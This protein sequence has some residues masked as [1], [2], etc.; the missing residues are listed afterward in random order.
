MKNP[1]AVVLANVDFA[2]RTIDPV[3]SEDVAQGLGD[4]R[5]GCLRLL[6]L[7]STLLDVERAEEG[8]FDAHRKLVDARPL[9]EPLLRFRRATAKLRK[10]SLDFDVDEGAAFVDGD[11][12]ARV[13]ENLVDNA[14]QHTLRAGRIHVRVQVVDRGLTLRVA[15]TAAPISPDEAPLLFEK[16]GR[17]SGGSRDRSGAGFGLYFCRLVAEAHGGDIRVGSEGEFGVVFTVTIPSPP[18]AGS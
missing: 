3:A 9:I 16:Y 8:R 4:A 1:M 18:E 6:R 14:L 11:L 17:G 12:I 7:F 2:L 10:L 15:N 13:V 5:E